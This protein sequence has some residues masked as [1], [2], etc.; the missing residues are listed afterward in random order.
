MRPRTHDPATPESSPRLERLV[1]IGLDVAIQM[2][3]E[4]R[5]FSFFMIGETPAGRRVPLV[6]PVADREHERQRLLY[7][8]AVLDIEGADA[9]VAVGLGVLSWDTHYQTEEQGFQPSDDPG[10][11]DAVLAFAADAAGNH[12]GAWAPYTTEP[13]AGVRVGERELTPRADGYLYRLLTPDWAVQESY[14]EFVRRQRE[15]ERR[16]KSRT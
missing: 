9:Y 7:A 12:L 11:Q 10:R 1:R 5:R 13:G 8:R 14:L 15:A 4:G 6:L 3:E 2:V 16:K